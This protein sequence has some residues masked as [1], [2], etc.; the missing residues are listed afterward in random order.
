MEN[1][2]A[3]A[4][5]PA[6]ELVSRQDLQQRLPMLFPSPSSLEWELRQH[7]DEYISGGAVF[8]ISRRF[9]FHPPTFERIALSI[10]ARRAKARRTSSG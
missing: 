10:A 6:S 4:P 7:L 9:F 8:Q 1:L 2:S 3:V 5:P